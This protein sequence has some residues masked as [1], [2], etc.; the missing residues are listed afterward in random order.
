[1]TAPNAASKMLSE[2]VCGESLSHFLNRQNDWGTYLRGF[3]GARLMTSY[4]DAISMKCSLN[5]LHY[6]P[7]KP[8]NV[9]R[10]GFDEKQ[11]LK[12]K[13]QHSPMQ[14]GLNNQENRWC[15]CIHVFLVC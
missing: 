5:T 13:L 14:P 8:Q 11:N 15:E 6:D 12:P 7:A 9:F 2:N 3:Q 1:M 10:E 4:K